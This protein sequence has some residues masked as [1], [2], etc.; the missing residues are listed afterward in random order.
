MKIISCKDAKKYGLKHYFT[1]KPCK[2]G[3]I[4][5]RT[6]ADCRCVQCNRDRSVKFRSNDP[7]RKKEMDRDYYLNNRGRRIQ[8][9]KDYKKANLEEVIRK[10]KE[11]Y[12]ANKDEL[13]AKGKEYR[14]NNK[15]KIFNQK[16]S[17]RDRNKAKISEKKKEYYR[18]NRDRLLAE[19]KEKIKTEADKSKYNEYFKNRRKEDPDFKCAQQC[20]GMLQRILRMT[21]MKKSSAT[22]KLLGYSAGDFRC[23]IESQFVDGMSW[24]NHGEWHVDHIVPAIKMV[25]SGIT[26]PSI[27]NALDNLQPLWAVDNLAKGAK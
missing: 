7:E 5:E 8:Q 6:S 2:N 4:C 16:K 1:G 13:S 22:V 25:R 10:K 12:N 24:D 15:E 3:H 27:I 26:D 20:R 14:E 18:A 9:T 23:H 19:K 17:Y 21:D 11:Y